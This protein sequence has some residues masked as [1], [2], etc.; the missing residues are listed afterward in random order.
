VYNLEQLGAQI[1]ANG[2]GGITDIKVGP[3]GYVYILSFKMGSGIIY[4]ISHK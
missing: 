1:F 4:R 3:D 2:F